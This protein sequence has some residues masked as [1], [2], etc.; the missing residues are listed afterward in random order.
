M[1]DDDL[2]RQLRRVPE[3]P[4]ETPCIDDGELLD[5]Q[6]GA[7]LLERAELVEAHLAH[8]RGCRQLLQGLAQPVSSAARVKAVA[9]FDRPRAV[10]IR[11]IAAGLGVALAAGLAMF[12]WSSPSRPLPDYD[13]EGPSG[14]I[15]AERGGEVK[16]PEFAL[17]GTIRVLLRPRRPAGEGL[18]LGVF[19]VEADDGLVDVTLANGSVN[20][21]GGAR[22]S[23][24]VRQALGDGPGRYRLAIVISR[25]DPSRWSGES[26]EEA[27]RS[28]GDARWWIT[29]VT[30]VGDPEGSE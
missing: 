26:L 11:R 29:E 12:T 18:R 14:G 30:V 25:Q 19:R 15:A 2:D 10:P 13:L 23:A 24:P 22:W 7:L 6:R 8:C 16:N 9:S 17:D 28:Q 4:T 1:N 27:R 3:A 20:A 5:Y 21:D